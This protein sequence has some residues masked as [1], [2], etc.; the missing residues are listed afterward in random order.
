MNEKRTNQRSL[1]YRTYHALTMNMTSFSNKPYTKNQW[2]KIAGKD[3]GEREERKRGSSNLAGVDNIIIALQY[4]IYIFP[5]SILTDYMK[6][7]L[8][9]MRCI[10]VP[11]EQCVL[12]KHLNR[13]WN[14][15]KREQWIMKRHRF[16]KNKMRTD[17]M[18]NL[19]AHFGHFLYNKKLHSIRLC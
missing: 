15:N 17:S 6:L 4:I 9:I 19:L 8:F 3:L 10:S 11:N 14:R 7:N 1:M 5:Q 18:Q 16:S 2:K 13:L 12:Y